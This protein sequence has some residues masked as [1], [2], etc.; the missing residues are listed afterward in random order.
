MRRVFVED[1]LTEGL[2]IRRFTACL[3][4]ENVEGPFRTALRHCS[5]RPRPRGDAG[6]GFGRVTGV[7]TRGEGCVGLET[8][9]VPSS[10]IFHA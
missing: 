7:W 9:Q 10:L 2:D 5:G 8:S 6:Y 4:C 3:V 1:L